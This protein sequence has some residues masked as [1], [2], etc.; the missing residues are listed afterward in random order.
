MSNAD[1][2]P[3]SRMVLSW[4]HIVESTCVCYR[5]CKEVRTHPIG[6]PVQGRPEDARGALRAC[7][8]HLVA[9]HT[10]PAAPRTSGTAIE[11]PSA[12]ELIAVPT[13][14]RQTA[15]AA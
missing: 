10:T 5:R 8:R 14:S 7:D 9:D 1:S 12:C 3:N 4:F 13:P 15:S 11:G 6:E 2:A